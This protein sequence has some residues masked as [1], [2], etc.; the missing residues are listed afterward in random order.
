MGTPCETV[1]Y[2]EC[3]QPIVKIYRQY[4][5]YPEVH[6]KELLDFLSNKIVVDGFSP[7]QTLETTFNGMG[8][9]AAALIA[10]FKKNIGEFYLH[11]GNEEFYTNYRYEVLLDDNKIEVKFNGMIF[12]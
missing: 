12:K 11:N 1:I 10:H 6:G 5:G 3:R 4:D 2:D 8:C 9:L 7:K